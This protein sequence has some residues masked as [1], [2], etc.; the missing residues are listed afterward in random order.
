[1]EI[2]QLETPPYITLN[3][4][5]LIQDLEWKRSST[6]VQKS[7]KISS[8]KFY[9]PSA[10]TTPIIWG[11]GGGVHMLCSNTSIAANYM[12]DFD[13]SM[14]FTHFSCAA[15]RA[16]WKGQHWRNEVA[17]YLLL[18]KAASKKLI[19]GK[20][21]TTEN[22]I[23]LISS[24]DVKIQL[25]LNLVLIINSIWIFKNSHIFMVEGRPLDIFNIQCTAWHNFCRQVFSN[26]PYL[27]K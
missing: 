19:C 16:S 7:L 2:I 14:N 8:F 12:H 18:S 26:V 21:K 1:M 15:W 22:L 24:S 17:Y 23:L 3:I 6:Y 27:Y 11:W 10:Q 9:Q 4:K 20:L 5:T 25:P 13:T